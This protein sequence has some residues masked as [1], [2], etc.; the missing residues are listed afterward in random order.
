MSPQ[1]ENVSEVIKQVR[2]RIRMRDALRGAAVTIAVA[3]MSLLVVALIAGLLKQRQTALLVLRLLPIV[4]TLAAAWL[5]ILRPLRMKLN[6]R[7]RKRL[8]EERCALED[9]LLSLSFM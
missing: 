8:I 9:R 7:T 2:R 4:T 3:A 1:L 6:E 5:F